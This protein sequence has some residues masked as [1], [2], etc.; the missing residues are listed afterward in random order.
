VSGSP[1]SLRYQPVGPLDLAAT[2]APLRRGRGD[3]TLRWTDEGV[4]RATRTPLGPATER[5]RQAADGSV[6][7]E[8]WG[9][10]A[11]WVLDRAPRLLG[12][13]DDDADFRPAHPL[14]KDLHGRHRGLRICRTE[15]VWEAALGVILEQKVPTVEAFSGW[16]GL[17]RMLGEPAP[18]PLP[19]LLLAP[20]PEVVARTP[21]HAFHPLR[22]ERQRAQ[23]LRRAVSAAGRL[24]EAVAMPLA[25]AR[26]RLSAVPG[27]GSWTGAE[28]AMVALGDGDAV[29]VGDY[30]LPHLVSWALSGQPRATDARM[31]ELLEPYRGHRGR[32]IRL[33]EHAGIGPPRY[34]PRRALRNWAQT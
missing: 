8:A 5:L 3:P 15:S 7:V 25:D 12:S 11:E 19:G 2:I 26:R 17:V 33:L 27:M 14:L 9:P 30:H 21:Y 28:I 13:L 32:V 29:S 6:E 4:W 20:A 24:Q 34:G 10:G 23:T 31:L 1:L 18:G 16:R 22:V